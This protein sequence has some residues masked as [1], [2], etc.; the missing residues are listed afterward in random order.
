MTKPSVCECENKHN[1]NCTLGNLVK[2]YTDDLIN[3][4]VLGVLLQSN[5]IST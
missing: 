5:K 1:F 4:I 2:A 3:T